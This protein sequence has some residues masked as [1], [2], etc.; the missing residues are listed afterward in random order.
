MAEVY[1]YIVGEVSEPDHSFIQGD[2]VEVI[3]ADLSTQ[4]T[5]PSEPSEHLLLHKYDTAEAN[6]WVHIDEWVSDFTF[7]AKITV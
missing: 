6:E 1:T 4:R 5:S 2:I 7:N 3:T